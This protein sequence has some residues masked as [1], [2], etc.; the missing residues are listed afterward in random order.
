MTSVADSTDNI[1]GLEKINTIWKNSNNLIN[2]KPASFAVN[3]EIPFR[4]FVV[5]SEILNQTIPD[6]IP[7]IQNTIINVELPTNNIIQFTITPSDISFVTI[8]FLDYLFDSCNN[9]LPGSI[10]NFENF[11][12]KHIEFYYKRECYPT[13]YGTTKQIYTWFI[14]EPSNGNITNSNTKNLL[15][16][17]IPYLF[18]PYNNTYKFKIFYKAS[19]GSFVIIPLA[20]NPDFA[21]IDNK[22]GFLYFYGGA[23][24]DNNVIL[25]NI[26]SQN[27]TNPSPPYISYIRYNGNTGFDN[28]NIKGNTIIDGSLSIINDNSFIDISNLAYNILNTQQIKQYVE[29]L[30]ISGGS[31]NNS[32]TLNNILNS[33][34]DASFN[35]LD[36]SGFLKINE[37]EVATKNYIDNSFTFN[38]LFNE[39]SSNFGILENSF[40][41]LDLSNI[42][43]TNILFN[44]LSLNFSILDAQVQTICGANFALKINEISGDVLLIES[45]ILSISGRIDNI[46]TI[47]NNLD[48]SYLTD[49]AFELSYNDL[50]NIYIT[51]SLFNELSLNFS[52]LENSF[53]SLDLSNTL[54]II[55]SSLTN[56]Q[57]NIENINANINENISN[58]FSFD[59]I[60][61][62]NTNSIVNIVNSNGNKYV[63]NN[64]NTYDASKNYGLRIGTYVLKNIPE[65]HPIALLNNDVSNLI[66]YDGSRNIIDIVVSGGN[67]ADPYYTFNPDINDSN[68][69]FIPGYTYRFTGNSISENH[70]FY[71]SDSGYK[72]EST[73][74][75]FSGS[76]SHNSGITGTQS[77]EMTIP[78]N[79]S[80]SLIT[81][82]CTSHSLMVKTK[83]IVSSLVNTN[84]YNFYYGDVSINVLGDF[85][86]ISVYCYY[87]GY[88]GGENLL[89]YVSNFYTTTN[90]ELQDLS[91]LFF[92]TITP[93][94][95]NSNILI[96]INA[97]LYCSY[98]LEERISVQLWRDLSMLTQSNNLG[99]LIATGG[100]TIPYNLTYLDENIN[101][102]QKK[103]YLKYILENNNSLQEMGIINIQNSSNYGNSRIILREI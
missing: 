71:I 18:D 100:L 41:N 4:N 90:S 77:F 74:L 101:N 51:N 3:E 24:T 95:N 94:K 40:V 102:S 57:N 82:Y 64:S 46:K 11:G 68:F 103:Y 26:R 5:S 28:L 85:G 72:Q 8:S 75:T 10:C 53:V 27:D 59:N 1:G 66:T 30:N 32:L 93:S 70:P 2:T 35:N 7:V 17:T 99:S 42:Y 13:I 65:A 88:M 47:V 54:D 97:N 62:L 81:Y 38:S 52:I 78:Y 22:S 25:D 9:I 91:A 19:N 39:L 16:N 48:V 31:N 36:I 69:Y 14:P 87:H 92:N 76:G 23:R 6:N 37:K 49:S 89:I 98:A 29:N 56:L 79:F 15:K 61:L 50:S 63:F 60:E 44:D 45:D 84:Y 55:D 83:S 67:F 33:N 12:Y 86:N 34:N 43:T 73:E 21:Y 80:K 20:S 58:K 96:N